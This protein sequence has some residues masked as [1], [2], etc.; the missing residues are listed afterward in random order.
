MSDKVKFELEFPIHASPNML[1]QYISSTVILISKKESSS[2]SSHLNLTKALFFDEINSAFSSEPSQKK[3]KTFPLE[4][5]LSAN[6]SDR[7]EAD[8][9]Y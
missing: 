8:D 3:E 6:H 4:L 9:M 2:F 1:Y 7:F 5:T